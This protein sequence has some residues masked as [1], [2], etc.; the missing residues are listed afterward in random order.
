MP[1]CRTTR[2]T[3]TE[4]SRRPCCPSRRARRRARNSIELTT[5]NFWLFTNRTWPAN[6]APDRP[7]IAA[8]MTNAHSLN[9]K[10]GTPMISAA[11]SSSRMAT[12]ARPTR[13]RS[14]LPTNS[15]TTMM[16]RDDEP[17]PRDAVRVCGEQPACPSGIRC[18]GGC[19]DVLEADLALQRPS[20][21]VGQQP[22]DLA[23]PERDD[24]Q[25]VAAQPQRRA[26]RGAAPKNIGDGHGHGQGAT[27]YGQLDQ[28]GVRAG[29]QRRDVGADGEEA[30]VAQVEQAR[31]ADDDVQPD[32]DQRERTAL[33]SASGSCCP[34]RS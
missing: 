32:R 7:P 5:S 31:L 20:T 29:Q 14:R 26:P 22:D 10:V 25:V 12:Q 34:V 27:R 2:R 1:G 16:M 30:D 13:L 19:A 21:M 33:N 3:R 6:S 23:E 18:P 9:L 28:R 11:S 15:S 24:G 4:R 17:V 8:P